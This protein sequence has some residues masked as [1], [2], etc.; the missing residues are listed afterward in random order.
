[1]NAD[2]RSLLFIKVMNKCTAIVK[3]WEIVDNA[4]YR[5]Y[6]VEYQNVCV[7]FSSYMS[8]LLNFAGILFEHR[9][10]NC[11]L[12]CNKFGKICISK[13]YYQDNLC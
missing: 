4:H 6:Y 7:V 2:L 13:H 11:P 8:I 10:M 9:L 3:R 5:K 12:S 1:M